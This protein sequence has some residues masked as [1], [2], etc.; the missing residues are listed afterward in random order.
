MRA[1]SPATPPKELLRRG[2]RIGQHHIGST[3]NT[4]LLAY[5]GASLPLAI[6]FILSQQSLG[7]IA[8]SEVVAVEIVRTLVGS[9]GLVAAV[10]VTTWLAVRTVTAV[11]ESREPS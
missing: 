8:N 1:A 5:L 7:S 11:R 4:L 6:L 3:V 10:P 9:I 2:L